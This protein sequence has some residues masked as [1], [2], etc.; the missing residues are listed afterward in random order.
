MA[1]AEGRG[2]AVLAV[3]YDQRVA[4]ADPHA[5][6]PRAAQVGGDGPPKREIA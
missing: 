6:P 5:V 4:D 3:G 1:T 2:V